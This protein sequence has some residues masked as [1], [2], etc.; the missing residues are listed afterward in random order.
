MLS[1][2]AEDI[3]VMQD[4]QNREYMFGMEVSEVDGKYLI[5]S[6][7]RDTSRVCA[8]CGMAHHDLAN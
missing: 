2:V 7:A 6:I 1:F 3:L 4:Q 8:R 5:L